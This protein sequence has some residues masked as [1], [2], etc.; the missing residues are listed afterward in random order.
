MNI[1]QI[2]RVEQSAFAMGDCKADF[3]QQVINTT[4]A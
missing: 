4:L 3:Q 2:T 1:R